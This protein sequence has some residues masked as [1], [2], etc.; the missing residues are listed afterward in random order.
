MSEFTKELVSSPWYWIILGINV[1]IIFI[2]IK[3]GNKIIGWFGE[4]W[5]KDEIKKLPSDRYKILN[6]I[7]IMLN[8]KTYQIDH[9]IVSCYG[10]FV[11]E[12][13]Q[14]NGVIT[15][16]KYDKYWVRHIGNKK[17]YYNNPI[18][19]NYGHKKA[20]EELLDL[21]DYKVISLVNVT[22]NAKLKIDHD[23]EL[24]RNYSI[25]EK[26]YSYK[27]EIISNVD[28]IY[29]EILANN[30]T[31][32]RIRKEHIESIK[33]KYVDDK[34]ISTCPKCGAILKERTGKYGKFLGCSNYPNCKYTRDIKKN[35]RY[36]VLEDDKEKIRTTIKN[37]L[38]G[39]FGIF[40]I[41]L[42]IEFFINY[43]N[44][45]NNKTNNN[46]SV[47]EETNNN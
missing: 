40:L 25:L 9:I 13:K 4:K 12:T 7:M 2:G 43:T 31:D 44:S 46:E 32:K 30:I 36:L 21:P 45:I 23:G 39:I 16:N 17:C 24:V 11:I 37:I 41:L 33:N 8:G 38:L 26:I 5:T 35:E 15:G 29:N 18:K 42:S 47:K 34:D 28:D 3:Y 22:S 27:K 10:I 20:L 14:Y 6:D 19:Q 1:L